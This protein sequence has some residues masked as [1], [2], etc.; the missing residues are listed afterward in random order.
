MKKPLIPLINKRNDC[1]QTPIEYARAIVNHFKPFGKVLEPCSG[2]GNF[3][4]VYP[5]AKSCEILLGSDFF[6]E[7]GNYDWI[8]TNPPYSQLRSFLNHSME[9]AD[10]IVFLAPINHLW[11]KARI[12]D[13]L[14][15]NFG[16][17]EIW[18][19]D[20]PK[21]F[22]QSGFQMGCFYVKRGWKGDI[23]FGRFDNL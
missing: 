1:V 21:S 19:F 8:I 17:K 13:V 22:P 23:T 20:T 3:L 16:I 7:K 14:Q 5:F 11:F 6:E 9:L 2:E 4:K 18:I 10:N 15:S 12:R